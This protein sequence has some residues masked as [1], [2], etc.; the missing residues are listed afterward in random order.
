MNWF[1]DSCILA[2]KSEI[3][4]CICCNLAVANSTSSS[5]SIYV[6]TLAKLANGDAGGVNVG[7]LPLT[8]IFADTTGTTPEEASTFTASV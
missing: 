1:V 3:W 6:V 4:D 2:L 7:A 5:V 8:S